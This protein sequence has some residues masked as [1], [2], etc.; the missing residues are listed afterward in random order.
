MA[1][2]V[3]PEMTAWI[4][5]QTRRC[6][7]FTSRIASVERVFGKPPIGLFRWEHPRLTQERLAPCSA[8]T[9]RCRIEAK[10][11]PSRAGKTLPVHRIAEKEPQS[12]LMLD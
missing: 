3:V 8:E 11:L 7:L 9:S 2:L 1:N 5:R 4:K 12:S 10:D 6:P